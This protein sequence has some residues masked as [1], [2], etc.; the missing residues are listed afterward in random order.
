MSDPPRRHIFICADDYGISPGVNRA[1]RDLIAR[2][3]INAASVM[4]AAP[5]LQRSEA[6]ALLD[7]VATTGAAIGLHLTLTAPFPPLSHGFAPLRHGAFLSLVATLHRAHLRLLKPELLTIEI[8]RQFEAFDAAFGRAPDFVDGHQHVQLFPQIREALLRVVKD[9]A[10]NA[11]VRQCGRMVAARKRF[12]DR[13]ALL[14]DALSRRFRRLARDLGVRTNPAFAG[15]YTFRTRADYSRLFQDFLDGMRDGGV[16]MCHPG[17]VDAELKRLDP[18]TDLR[19]R[20]YA[21]FRE[22]SFPRLLAAHGVALAAS[23]D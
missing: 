4:V 23:P 7:V 8:V 18:L 16:I 15:T 22:D 17:T 14:L 5:S 10:P 21:F 3:R 9:A 19:E 13:K 11:W 20:E 1:I 6:T 12:A 2:R